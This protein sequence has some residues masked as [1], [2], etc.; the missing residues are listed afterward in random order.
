VPEAF[1]TTVSI[2]G[3]IRSGAAVV[4]VEALRWKDRVSTA[5]VVVRIDDILPNSDR[6]ER[7]D[8]YSAGAF[9]LMED[10]RLINV[11]FDLVDFIIGFSS[12]LANPKVLNSGAN[13]WCAKRL[14]LD[15]D[16][17]D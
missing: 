10:I 11:R 14:L 2:I 7:D 13:G 8:E 16:V 1:S 5:L 17:T 3:G 15:F 12:S 4:R 6:L 9:D